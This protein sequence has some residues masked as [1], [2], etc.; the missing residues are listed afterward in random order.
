MCVS[1]AVRVPAA[2]L[3]R[4]SGACQVDAVAGRLALLADAV[5]KDADALD[6]QFDEVP[7][8]DPTVQLQTAATADRAAAQ[9][10][11]RLQR[12]LGRERGDG[13]GETEDHRAER[14]LRPGL[15]VDPR[16]HRSGGDV[17]VVRG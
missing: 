7:G 4:E 16:A 5:V 14:P 9:H 6:L 3:V 10:V 15:T 11:P 2:R 8:L 17:D 1:D 12:L 13:L